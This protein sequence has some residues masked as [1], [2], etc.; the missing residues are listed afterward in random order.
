MIKKRL[1]ESKRGYDASYEYEDMV[2][3]LGGDNS[4]EPQYRENMK[5]DIEDCQCAIKA[6][7]SR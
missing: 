2:N 5:K 4:S 7:K 3:I 1:A 6:L